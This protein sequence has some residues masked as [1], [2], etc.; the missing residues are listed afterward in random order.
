MQAWH[1]TEMPWPHLPEGRDEVRINLPNSYFDPAVGAD[2]YHRYLDEHCLADELGLDIMLNEHHGTP[3]CLNAAAP[4]TAMALARQT[5]R[6][7]ICILGNPI[8][9]REDP[10]R[11]AE[12]M[13]MIDCVSRGRLE[14]GFVR[15][16]PYEI[17]AS[18]ANPSE[19]VERLWEGVDLVEKAWTTHDGPFNYE[20]RFW[21]KRGINIWPRPFQQPR[22]PIWITS[23]SDRAG[24]ARMA[25]RG[26]VF[27]IFL[28]PVAT[29]KAMFDVYRAHYVEQGQPGGGGMAYMPLVH[30]ADT[31]A[32]AMR[33]AEE[34]NWYLT[35]AKAPAHYRDPPGYNPVPAKARALREA[36]SGLT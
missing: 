9:N 14:C 26:Y 18:N 1:F 5:S 10:I 8:S 12:E 32:E 7:R 21:H 25:E 13:A 4:L 11:I 15:G 24:V 2:L 23:S 28:Q 19:T 30:T 22:P 35:A 3:T 20:G 31:E 27:A 17:Y 33:G 34:L 29:V 16:V 6:A 36:A